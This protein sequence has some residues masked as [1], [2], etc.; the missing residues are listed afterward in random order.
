MFH[1]LYPMS[2]VR[3]LIFNVWCPMTDVLCPISDSDVWCPM[4]DFRCQMSGVRFLMSD[5]W[6]S[7]PFL[8]KK[9]THFSRIPMRDL[10][11]S[12]LVPPQHDCNINFCP[13]GLFEFAPLSTWQSGLDKVSTEIQELS[14]TDCNFQG[15]SRC[16]WTL[17]LTEMT[18]IIWMTI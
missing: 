10:S 14:S 12:F 1:V 18:G 13:K 15:L 4:P 16:V 5:I 11:L 6:C 3:C 8:N 7:Y 9:F 2:N 17:R